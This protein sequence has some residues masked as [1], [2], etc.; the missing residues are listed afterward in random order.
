MSTRRLFFAL[1]PDA[2]MRQELAHAASKAV[3]AAG[4]RPVPI[5]NLHVTLA[6][7]GSVPEGSLATLHDIAQR[8]SIVGDLGPEVAAVT[9]D[10]I[11]YWPRSQLVCATATRAS[12]G[13]RVIAESL[14]R[15]LVASGF[16][17]DLKPFREHVT[18]VRK[19]ARVTRELHMPEVVWSFRHFS[20][21]ESRTNP[22]G[23]IYS[24]LESWPLCK[25]QKP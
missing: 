7:L 13:T 6:F 8:V 19:V 17:P 23:S 24:C 20:L 14:K 18:L 4:G 9:L 2:S 15:E 16:A 21:I 10:R 12:E 1:W 3:R 25:R 5:E 11:A 22:E